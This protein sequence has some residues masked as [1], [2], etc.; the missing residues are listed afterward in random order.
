MKHKRFIQWYPVMIAVVILLAGC[1]TRKEIV[2]ANREWQISDFYGQIIDQDSTYRMTF[3]NVLIPDSLVII[4][5]AESASKYPGMERFIADILHTAHLDSA[6]ILF[7]APQMQTMFVRLKTPFPPL[8]P[9]SIS[10]PMH[11]ENPF[12]SWIHEEDIEDWTR[13]STE[14]YTYSFY[15]KRKRQLLIVDHYDYGD[16]PVA[17]ITV[18]QTKNKTT[19]RM[20]VRDTWRTSY[21]GL[22]NMKEFMRDIE[23]WS[24]NVEFRRA[25]AFANYK[26]GQEQKLGKKWNAY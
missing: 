10:S 8:K 23:F 12:T 11:D 13:D 1:A 18:F 19:E 25:H 17:Q 15:N 7:Y 6:E 4:S 9:S 14:M 20:N 2:F 26:I 5:C 21:F 3:G 22:H 16:I 24:N